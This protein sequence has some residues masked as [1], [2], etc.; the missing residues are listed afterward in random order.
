VRQRDQCYKAGTKKGRKAGMDDLA[1]TAVVQ[2]RA[3]ARGRGGAAHVFQ[4]L[5][6]DIIALP[7]APGTVLSRAELQHRFGLSSTPI[8]DALMRLQEEGLVEVFP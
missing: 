3:D 4:S 7:L 1:A 6:Q 2:T 8:R 5:R